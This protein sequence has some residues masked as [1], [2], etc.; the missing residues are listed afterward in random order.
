MT[1]PG[2]ARRGLLLGLACGGAARAAP[3]E[4]DRLGFQVF[5]NGSSIGTHALTFSRSD[6]S[7]EVGIAV[8]IA[9]GIGP[10][11][12]FRY[13]LRGTERWRGGQLVQADVTTND[14]G[15]AA[16]LRVRRDAE[17]LWVEGSRSG[18]Y[19]APAGSLLATHWNP[20]EV[21]APMVN[22]QDGTLFRPAVARAGPGPMQLPDGTRCACRRF[23][24]TGEPQMQLWYDQADIWCALQ[25]PGKDGSTI[26][27]HRT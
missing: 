11:V 19:L 16:F 4:P 17:G 10:L 15:R 2:I 3:A 24:L 8:D 14:N 6:D 13:R 21:D 18:R 5:R 25:A 20:A 9:V 7:L 12:L 26:T 22:P 23:T 1:A 27:Y